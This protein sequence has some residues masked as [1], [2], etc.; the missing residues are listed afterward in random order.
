M[1]AKSSKATIDGSWVGWTFP[2]SDVA[3]DDE[4][5]WGDEPGWDEAGDEAGDSVELDS[6]A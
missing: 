5:G 6:M 1:A 4:P 2:D 3:G